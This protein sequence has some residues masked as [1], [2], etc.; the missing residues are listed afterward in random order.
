MA[1]FSTWTHPAN[2]TVRVYI[3]GLAGQRGAKVWVEAQAADQFGFEYS[4]NARVPEGVH[5]NKNDLIND[6]EQE[7][8]KTAQARVK[9][10]SAVVA[11][12]K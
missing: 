7:I 10:F 12:A 5:T 9:E 4:I 1:T 3:S 11:L 8:F 2:G 6:A